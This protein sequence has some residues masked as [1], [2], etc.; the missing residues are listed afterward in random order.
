MKR[1]FSPAQIQMIRSSKEASQKLADIL[2]VSASCICKIRNGWAYKDVK[3]GAQ[4]V[5]TN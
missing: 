2:K 4:V 3:H 5:H 1:K